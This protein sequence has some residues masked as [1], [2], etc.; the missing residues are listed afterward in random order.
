MS[1]RQCV[2][3]EFLVEEGNS[4]AVVYERLR[5][6]YGEVCMGAS[7]VGRRVKHF[8][9]GNTDIAD[10]PRCGRPRSAANGRLLEKGKTINAARYVQTLNKLRCELRE[11][12]LKKK[13]VI[14]QHDSARPHTARLTL[15]TIQKNCSHIH[16]T[17]RICPP[18]IATYSD[19]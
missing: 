4:A 12:R 14:L 7:S 17:I 6:A 19:R 1:F 13:T 11:K 15:Q 5:G 3:I 9:D 8:K 16:P 10:Q 18:Q 2:V